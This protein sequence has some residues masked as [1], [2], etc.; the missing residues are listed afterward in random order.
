MDIRQRNIR[1]FHQVSEFLDLDSNKS[2]LV[3]D[4]V[5]LIDAMCEGLTQ[6]NEDFR[7]PDP[8]INK[9]FLTKLKSRAEWTE[10]TSSM[11]QGDPPCAADRLTFRQ[12]ADLAVERENKM[13][14]VETPKNNGIQTKPIAHPNND[15]ARER[16]RTLTQ[17]DINAFVV[18]QMGRDG[19]LQRSRTVTTKG[20]SK[21]PSQEEINDYVMQQMRRDQERKPP[22]TRIRSYSQPEPRAQHQ[23]RQRRAPMPRCTFCG[24]SYHQVGNCWR[25]WRVA[26]EAPQGNFVPKRVE[27]KTQ[28]PGQPPMYRSGFTLL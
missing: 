20:H 12:L 11:L 5:T 27:F 23:Q 9:L 18:R 22:L 26:V 15:G 4:F 17:E 1:M 14:G 19:T 8:Q 3:A 2:D 10:W 7:I 6:V 25:R 21:R 13:R 16:P 24:D 28:V